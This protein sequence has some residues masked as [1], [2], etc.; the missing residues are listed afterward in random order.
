MWWFRIIPS[1]WETASNVA[2]GVFGA[3][4]IL[5]CGNAVEKPHDATG[6]GT[7]RPP[8]V[9]PAPV[10]KTSGKKGRVIVASGSAGRGCFIEARANGETFRMLLDT[11]STGGAVTFGS[12][13]L[14]GLGIDAD[15][16]SYEHSFN[17]ANGKGKGGSVSLRELRIGDSFVLR[18]LP[19]DIMQTPMSFPL[20]G[21]E[22][23]DRLNL[24]LKD[25]KCLLTLPITEKSQ[26]ALSSPEPH[27][28]RA[29]QPP[30]PAVTGHQGGSNS[31]WCTG[32]ANLPPS[33]AMCRLVEHSGMNRLIENAR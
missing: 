33:P 28:A 22:L 1:V 16:F 19:A 9:R 27:Y 17:T 21:V 3:C 25:G 29:V 2:L 31:T 7:A 18:N 14:E 8:I 11:G 23:L 30:Q 10:E 24:Q 5:G 15:T 32:T 12:N 13:H 20:V 6:N 4:S 26:A